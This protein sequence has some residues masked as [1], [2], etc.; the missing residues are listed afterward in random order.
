M[1]GDQITVRGSIM[2]TLQ[3]MEHMINLIAG[4]G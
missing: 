2:E 1:L 4:R 3:D